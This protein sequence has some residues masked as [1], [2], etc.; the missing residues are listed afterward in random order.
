MKCPKCQTDNPDTQRF[1]GDC[2][3][4][5]TPSEE[6]PISHTKTLVAPAE[7]LRRGTRF[8]E[9]YEI[10]EELGKGGMGAVY[11]VKDVKL[12]E[13]MALKLLRPEIASDMSTIERFRNELKL[14]R[15]ITHKNVCRMH[16]FHEEVGIPFIT[17]EYVSGED[18]KS[19]MRK[20]GRISEDKAISIAKQV[21][22]GLSEAHELGVVH[23]DLKP[24]NIMIDEKGHAK[25]MDF[26]IARSVEAPGV[27]QTGVMIGT[28][29]YI[30]P[31]QAEGE[32]ADQRSDIYSLGV[33]LYE[34]VTG[35][36]PFRG[37]TAF[38]VALKHKAQIPVDPRKLNPEVSEDFN[39][40]ILICMEKD[41]GRRYQEVGALLSDLRNI[42]D[43]FPL[44]TKIRPRRKTFAAAL[45]R[46]KL[47]IPT[48]VVALV[49]IAVVVWQLIPQKEAILAPKIQNSIAVISFENLTGDESYDIFQK[50]IPNLLITNLE[51]T[52]YFYVV[53]RER[54]HDL[55]KQM[56]KRNVEFIES[57]MGFELCR[58]EGVE[59]LVRG[60]LNKAGDI[61]VTDVKVLDVETKR[62]L[63]SASS[64]GEGIDS[65]LKIQ[66]DEL[67]RIISQG[68]G[69]A[70]QKIESSP[71]KIVDVST[72][73]IQAYNN[74]LRALESWENFLRRDARELFEKAI[75]QDPDFAMAYRWLFRCYYW[76]EE[77]EAGRKFLVRAR[78]LSHK[79]TER[80]RLWI[81]ADYAVFIE[82][83]YEKRV[84]ILE[85]ITKKFPR[86]KGAYYSQGHYYHWINRDL[87]KAME[88]YRKELELNPDHGQAL[89]GLG[90]AYASLRNFE[91]AL[92]FLNRYA[93]VLPGS[94]N[95]L[96]SIA[97][98]YLAMGNYDKAIEKAL[99]ALKINPNFLWPHEKII[100]IH[101]L[102]EDYQEAMKWLDQ[103][104]TATPAPGPK[105]DGILLKG[106]YCFWLGNLDL[107]LNHLDKASMHW[108][109]LGNLEKGALTDFLKG[110]VHYEKREFGRSREYFKS[111]LDTSISD[112][113]KSRPYW[114]ALYNFC[115]GF[116]DLKESQMNSV[117]SRLEEM[118]SFLPE[119]YRADREWVL[120]LHKYLKAEL[121]LSA[122]SREEVRSLLKETLLKELF[123]T[124]TPE[125]IYK[126][127][128]ALNRDVLAQAYFQKGEIDKAIAEYQRLL[129]FNPDRPERYLIHP[130]YYYRLA[131]L[132]EEQGKTAKAIEN[133]NKF[134]DLWKD[135]DP[136]IAE[137]EDTKNRLANLEIE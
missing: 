66:I 111:W 21:C 19:V 77:H 31:E 119:L 30:S 76:L 53:T 9:R 13:E 106:F 49:I 15:K 61:F 114:E 93:S 69:I 124:E 65:V 112:I 3:T 16:D 90:F 4:Q 117:R 17:M 29:D 120:T 137:V 18:L 7:E 109:F 37:D 80:E 63:T 24:Q 28:P 132:Y 27:T 23:R 130:K 38:S 45:V 107:A 33:I 36:V 116:V 129:T 44:G 103:F 87:P 123:M 85:Q 86:E 43:G 6:L 41:R 121:L 8:A 131:K 81:E 54:M 78:E 98:V 62:L 56:G 115:L 70:R 126:N 60:S 100:Y 10:I 20:E 50:S 46:K 118:K 101:A 58:R 52:G 97:A 102:K 94:T 32:E 122:S 82:K 71:F 14:A 25:I 136:G 127:L 83:D 57:D 96:D 22:E 108:E 59:A 89:N 104:I 95:P 134:L 48:M 34:M 92:E 73:S 125:L 1:C 40:L 79:A 133:Y 91:K 47:F 11:R 113:P 12:D 135:A 128:F 110:W 2:G 26:G 88:M 55:L 67:S 105:A 5:L 84:R 72:T 39:R 99:E 35:S 51:N 42:E 68:M 74:Y 75:Q 64:K